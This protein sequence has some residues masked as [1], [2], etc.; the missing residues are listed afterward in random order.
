M[1]RKPRPGVGPL[2]LALILAAGASRTRAQLSLADD[3]IIAAS[4]E[5]SKEDDDRESALPRTPGEPSSL[6][7][8]LPIR[9]PLSVLEEPSR[10]HREFLRRGAATNSFRL[11]RRERQGDGPSSV[12]SERDRG[13]QSREPAI[14]APTLVSPSES[15]SYGTFEITS[16]DTGPPGGLT[17]DQAIQRLVTAN[18]E[19]RRKPTRSRWPR[20][21]SSPRACGRTR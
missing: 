8:A 14:V 12:R 11:I 2:V 19:L 7:G 6:F 16:E 13:S 3:I 4:E 10:T 20:R 5:K 1:I 9:T 15:A 21:R 17:L 18:L